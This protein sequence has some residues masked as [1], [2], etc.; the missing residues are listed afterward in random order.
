MCGSSP[1]M[2]TRYIDGTEALPYKPPQLSDIPFRD[3]G[4][5][6]RAAVIVCESRRAWPG[7]ILALLSEESREADLSTEQAGAQAPSWLPDPD[8]YSGRSQG[9]QCAWGAGPQGAQGMAARPQR[10]PGAPR[11]PLS[12]GKKER[13]RRPRS[14]EGSG[15]HVGAMERLKRRKDFLAAAAG[16]S[17]STPGFVVQELRRK[18]GGPARVGFTVS[19]KV[20]GAVE[21]NRVRRQLREVVRLSAATSLNPGSDYVVVG[22]R[23]ALHIAF[24]SLPGAFAGALRRL[25]K[26]RAGVSGTMG[27]GGRQTSKADQSR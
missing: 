5:A 1:R 26:R 24:V 23:A 3:G 25:E 7:I 14:R 10:G 11:P 9:A 6:S 20:G 17:V 22:R 16:T 4:N 18:G 27:E 21:R 19:R 13:A 12:L 8:G 2:T 15:A